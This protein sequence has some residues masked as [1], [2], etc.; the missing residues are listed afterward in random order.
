MSEKEMNIAIL[1]KLKDIAN[2]IFNNEIKI[3][4]GTYTAAELANGYI[5]F[6]ETDNN[7]LL[8]RSVCV[9][10]FRCTFE[11]KNIFYLVYKFEKLVGI[12]K[13]KIHFSKLIKEEPELSFSFTITKEMK[14]LCKCVSNKDMYEQMKY[15]FID[16]R[17]GYIV[18]SDA[19]MFKACKAE[20]TGVNGKSDLNIMINPKDFK[21][22]TG[23]CKVSVSKNNII[24]TDECGLSFYCKHFVYPDWK[25]IVPKTDK[26]KNNFIK[27]KEYNKLLSFIN[28]KKGTF[29]MYSSVGD[30]KVTVSF[31]NIK[32]EVCTEK[33]V[34]FHFSVLMD[35]EKFKNI[36]SEW[37]GELFI[38]A[39]YK[40][41]LLSDINESISIILPEG[42]NDKN[43]VSE[44]Y[45]TDEKEEEEKQQKQQEYT[46]YFLINNIHTVIDNYIKGIDTG[47][48]FDWFSIEKQIRGPTFLYN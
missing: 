24:I 38:E 22:L 12:R 3:D 23:V 37:T 47:K 31:E 25:N 20:F 48:S 15:I 5:E 9:E 36:S 28:K 43:F 39:N 46:C 14:T 35:V 7:D 32:M 42:I 27:I 17:Q 18:A 30:N 4:N 2:E 33:K 26:K 41:I 44:D 6:F 13:D 19:R 34:P 11:R 29:E 16:H 8:N 1:G 21:R 45:I 10:N 40:P